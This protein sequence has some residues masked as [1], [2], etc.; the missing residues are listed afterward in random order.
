MEWG[1]MARKKK[2]KQQR[3]AS[4]DAVGIL[5][6]DLKRTGLWIGIAVAAIGILAVVQKYIGI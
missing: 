2:Q 3:V 6:R 5:N 4:V 1:W